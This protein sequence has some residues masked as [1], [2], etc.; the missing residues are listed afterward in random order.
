SGSENFGKSKEA[1][2]LAKNDAIENS[3]KA[4][5]DVVKAQDK[6][7]KNL[8]ENIL[9]TKILGE[10]SVDTTALLKKYV[11][12]KDYDYKGKLQS[13]LSGAGISTIKVGNKDVFVLD[14]VDQISSNTTFLTQARDLELNA[15]LLKSEDSVVSSIARGKVESTLNDIWVK[16]E[17]NVAARNFQNQATA[18]PGLESIGVGAYAV[19]NSIKAEY[20]GG[21]TT[22]AVGDILKDVP[23]QGI[24]YGNIQYYVELKVVG[25]NYQ[26][27]S[28]YDEKRNLVA[29]Q[30]TTRT[31]NSAPTDAKTIE[32][33][34]EIL[35]RFVFN[36][37]DSSTYNNPY[38]TGTARIQYF[39]SGNYA[40]FPAIVPFDL[41]HGWYAAVKPTLPI[42]SSRKAYEASGRISS[43]WLCNIGPNQKQEPSFYGTSDDTCV[44]IDTSIN[45][46]Y[47]AITGLDTKEGEGARLASIAVRAIAEASDAHT[48]GVENVRI[49]PPSGS[50]PAIEVGPPAIG[51]PDIQCQDFMSPVDC[52]LLF[53]VCDP[54]ICP[55]SRCDLGGNYHVADVVQSGVLG[56]IALCLPNW[57]EVKVPV[58]L[59]GIHAG[60]DSYISVLDN[61]QS[62]LQN[63]LETGQQIGICDELHSVY[64]CQFLW[65]QGLPIANAVGP[66]LVG[67]VLGKDSARGG[68]EYLGMQQAWQ[69]AK[70][71]ANY[72]TQNY[73]VQSYQAFKARSTAGVG[74]AF[75]QNW[76]S[77][78]AP[79][80]GSLLDSITKP[81]VPTQFY[82]RFDEIPYTTAT[83]PP[84][85]QYKVFYHIYAGDTPASYQVYMKGTSQAFFQDTSS[86]RVVASDFIAAENYASESIDFIAPSGYTQLCISVNNQEECGFKQV[87]T[88]YAVTYIADQ[89]AA[90]EAARTD[91]TS[92]GNCVSGTPNML[93][94]INPNLQAGATSALNPEIYN[95][96]ITR[97]C[98]T[99]NPGSATDEEPEKNPRWVPVGYCDTTNIG[100]WLDTKS[101]KTA[102]KN[103]G[104]AD[105]VTE[106]TTSS[107]LE[108]LKKERGF[109]SDEDFSAHT[110]EIMVQEDALKQ[111]N[112]VNEIFPNVF[113]KNKKGFLT[114]LRG[115]AYG[116][117]V[118]T[119]FAAMVKTDDKAAAAPSGDSAGG[120]GAEVEAVAA[121]NKIDSGET[122]ATNSAKR[123]QA[124]QEAAEARAEVIKEGGNNYPVIQFRDGNAII[125]SQDPYFM[126]SDINGENKWTWSLDKKAFYTYSDL[127]PT[128]RVTP[129][130]KLKSKNTEFIKNIDS[131]DYLNGVIALFVRVRNN[132]EGGW[133]GNPEI[134][135]ESVTLY[136]DGKFQLQVTGS[137]VVPPQLVPIFFQFSLWDNYD[138]EPD[139]DKWQS[140]NKW[141][142]DYALDEASWKNVSSS[143]SIDLARALFGKNLGDGT[144]LIFSLDSKNPL[145]VPSSTSSA[146]S[147][148]TSPTSVSV[149][150][151]ETQE[152]CQKILGAEIVKIASSFKAV[153]IK[154]VPALADA[155]AD[156]VIK[157]DTG[158]PNFEC[159]VLAVAYQES[160]I[161]HCGLE[162]GTRFMENGNPLYCDGNVG[163]ILYG[164]EGKS[165]GVM[166]VNKDHHGVRSGFVDN[167]N[168]GVAI[169]TK[170]YNSE[171]KSYSC[172]K[173]S[174]G[175]TLWNDGTDF[176]SVSY[177]GWERALR[178]YNGWN[179]GCTYVK[180][181]KTVIRGDPNY[182]ENV[183]DPNSVN[184]LKSLFSEICG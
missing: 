35:S 39:E 179:D 163:T 46:P 18:I 157:R 144:A 123:I 120:D 164:D 122:G 90:S 76:I 9:T 147:G 153:Q 41:Q 165:L 154:S 103:T 125:G 48:A 55:T 109:L 81:R 49:T 93:G 11:D 128:I 88:D 69:A 116:S 15:Q 50:Q 53:N 181:G 67:K 40:G 115:D 4:Y 44:M 97:I 130:L 91:I 27:I 95:M 78:R 162:I 101:I 133:F 32:G 6:N 56:S 45:A 180:D 30:D 20:T 143:D 84:T 110:Q 127:S 149:G 33:A 151:C 10:S 96:G 25:S 139:P 58:C 113:E 183:L 3:V 74:T 34:K 174:P 161:Q 121:I 28:V 85:S 132:D 177:E 156:E 59:S 63:S 167:A 106:S 75:C 175:N 2:L 7:M 152:D 169:L 89:Y 77:L 29:T 119:A 66:T 142:W 138:T 107:F 24:L 31:V 8:Q 13:S 170:G 140:D 171:S 1:C 57:P 47:G 148:T 108:T 173:Q 102:I 79:D 21:K 82:G 70:D 64:M 104:T 19:A 155:L 36:S 87:S 54:V 42:G 111:I 26:V 135:T 150:S 72:F 14:I 5:A 23:L 184:T 86:R 141:Q 60:L 131:Y 105:S 118:S 158:L 166:Q 43:Y 16:V 99:G 168:T 114:L 176:V 159:L 52:N 172:S 182:V 137:A 38:P 12:D 71:S 68:G 37:Y 65:D 83:V 22:A 134:S 160:K 92:S 178:N 17:K 100:C 73:A 126:F 129:G 94:L 136:D 51:V 146:A 124:A 117:L 62:C 61:Y 80:G 145:V 98:S 112:L